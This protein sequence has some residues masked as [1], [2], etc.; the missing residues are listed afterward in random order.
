M[1][2]AVA[3]MRQAGKRVHHRASEPGIRQ[4]DGHVHLLRQAIDEEELALVRAFE[5]HRGGAGAVK[6]ARAQAFG[7]LVA[8]RQREG[9]D[10]EFRGLDM[11][12]EEFAIILT[13]RGQED[14]HLADHH[15]KDGEQE[16]PPRQ[17]VRGKLPTFA[18]TG[19][20]A[21]KHGWH[22]A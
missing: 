2:H 5:Q 22:R 21:A 4:I 3:A 6:N 16:Q 13:D 9:H 18:E 14:Q 20:D 19:A 7:K 12:A 10:R 15:V 8:A 11:V 1:Q 17:G